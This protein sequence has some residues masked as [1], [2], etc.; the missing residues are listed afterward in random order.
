VSQITGASRRPGYG[1]EYMDVQCPQCGYRTGVGTFSEPGTCPAC[2]TALMLTC[3]FRALSPEE[4]RAECE[5]RSPAV[6][7]SRNVVPAT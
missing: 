6:T 7:P 3:E 4:L 1:S 5:R 2:G